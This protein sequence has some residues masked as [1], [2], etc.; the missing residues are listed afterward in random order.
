MTQQNIVAQPFVINNRQ[1]DQFGYKA[2]LIKNT[3]NSKAQ[4]NFTTYLQRF[5]LFEGMF[6]KFMYVEGQ[7]FDGAGFVKTVGLQAG[8]IVRIDLFKEPEDSLDDIISND[9]YIESVGSATR[10]VSG[11]GEI[12]TFRAVSKI[13]FM[14]L[15]SKV[16]RSFSGKASEIIQQICDKFFDLEPG[17]VSA[18]NIEETFGVLNISASSL[19]PFSIIERVNSQAISTANR[20]GDNNFFFYE[21]RE[22]VIY[23]SL[24]KI[25]QDA[26]T[27]NYIIPAD[28]NRSQESKD[29]DYFRILEFEVKTTNNQRQKV[30]EGAL[31]NQTLT[32]DFISRKVEKNTFK[33]KDNYKDILLMG[34]NLAFDID[35][36]DNL[37]GDDQRTT[38]EEQ[39][40][41]ARCSNKSYDQQEDFISIKRGPTQAQ[42]ELMN[43]TVI[44]CRVLGNPKIKPGDII[45]LKAAQ[46]DPSDLEQRDPFLNGKFLVGSA[47]HV[48][49][50]AGTYE[51]I[52]DL[53]KDG[54]EFDISNFRKDTNSI[55]IQPKQ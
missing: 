9:F 47:M 31:E 42:Y 23:K 7:I 28:K 18:N 55:L 19:P 37:V 44:S 46:S 45:E 39:N 48:V 54:Y 12:F 41:F 27:F 24:R 13:G 25:V 40:V 20:A 8:D 43:Q 3:N 36:I 32:F 53:F 33:L 38:D 11:K 21:T 26:N 5:S 29:K 34:D 14:G 17:K 22:G 35:E 30:E 16:K 15:K 51:T 49:L 6:S 50:D 10:L 1:V 2:L 4:F 52:I